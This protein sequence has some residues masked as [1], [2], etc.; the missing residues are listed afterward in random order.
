MYSCQDV[1]TIPEKNCRPLKNGHF[2]GVF[3]ERMM[4]YQYGENG[5][6]NMYS[7][8]NQMRAYVE[9]SPNQ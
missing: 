8:Y 3:T 7:D 9:C 5:A 2:I 6:R 4:D 1:S